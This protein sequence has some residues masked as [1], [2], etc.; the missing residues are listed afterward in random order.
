MKRKDTADNK[1]KTRNIT[2][3]D[4]AKTLGVSK[5]TV[6]LA[7]NGDPRVALKTRQKILQAIGELGYIYNRGAAS[8]STGE[9]RAVG[10]AVHD[11]TNPYF[12]EV[13]AAIETVLSSNDRMSFLCNTHE[14]VERQQHFIAA[15]VERRADGLILCP[16]INTDMALLRPVFD[17]HLPTVLLTRDIAGAT[18]DFVGNDDELGLRQA[19]AHLIGL[20]HRRI[21]MLGGGQN[22]SVARARR[23]GFYAAMAAGELVVDPALVIDCAISPH[24]GEAAIAI[25]LARQP[26]PTAL[27]C[28]TDQIALGALSGLHRMGLRPGR[29]IAV[30]G[31]DDIEEA[32]RG[33]TQLTTVSINKA[34]IGEKAAQLLLRRI[35]EPELP[36]QRIIIQP[37]LV[38]RQSCGSF[39]TNV[40]GQHQDSGGE[41]G[42]Q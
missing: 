17:W 4:V 30:V 31:C 38:I 26:P 40:A 36:V 41:R 11:F 32:S 18:L 37:E 34:A 39:M 33:Y 20:G 22:N 19:T 6:S 21:G 13:C 25:A 14:S 35:A 42:E 15:L 24:G 10:L 3:Q 8:L 23:A 5:A 7:I 27:V 12:A 29:D 1:I 16:A 2:L 9:T 28:F